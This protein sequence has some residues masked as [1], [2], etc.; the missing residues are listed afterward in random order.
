L[1]RGLNR[2]L[3]ADEKRQ[4]TPVAARPQPLLARWTR[5][6]TSSTEQVP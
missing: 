2:H 3:I 4:R 6:T 5:L 1:D